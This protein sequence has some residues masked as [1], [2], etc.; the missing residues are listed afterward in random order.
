MESLLYDKFS[1]N[2]INCNLHR[3]GLVIEK[4]AKSALLVSSWVS[5][6][7][8]S[9]VV[10]QSEIPSLLIFLI[11]L[12]AMGRFLLNKKEVILLRV[13]EKS[14]QGSR[15]LTRRTFTLGGGGMLKEETVEPVKK[16]PWRTSAGIDGWKGD[17]HDSSRNITSCSM[18]DS[19]VYLGD[20][21]I[22]V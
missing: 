3:V 12:I 19:I 6:L 4:P 22:Y 16:Q 13:L 11:R 7:K 10:K 14:V 15:G 18:K 9:S 8:S 21:W 20:G 17:R 1:P 5:L 2:N